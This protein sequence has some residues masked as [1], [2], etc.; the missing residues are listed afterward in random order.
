M[1]QDG[2][3]GCYVICGMRVTWKEVYVSKEAKIV[4]EHYY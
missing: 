2:I 3:T 1:L 4:S